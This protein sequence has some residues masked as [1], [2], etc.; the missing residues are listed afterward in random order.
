LRRS[1]RDRPRDEDRG[2][3]SVLVRGPRIRRPTRSTGAHRD[4]PG[5]GAPESRWRH[6]HRCGPRD[7][8]DGLRPR[9]LDGR[10]LRRNPSLHGEARTEVQGYVSPLFR[11]ARTC[12]QIATTPF[13][14]K[15]CICLAVYPRERR[16]SS[17]SWPF[18]GTR[19][20]LRVSRVACFAG[21]AITWSFQR[22]DTSTTGR[23]PR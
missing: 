11:S 19:V 15:V 3:R 22:P 14:A 6:A 10:H 8:G 13:L 4:P 23:R 18:A 12:H 16:I 17:V 1:S 2:E 5:E 20:G 21:W 7:G 9:R